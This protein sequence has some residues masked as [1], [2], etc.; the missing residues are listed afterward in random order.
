MI[1]A[2]I[3]ASG[4]NIDDFILSRASGYRTREKVASIV[5]EKDKIEF[6]NICE[7]KSKKL[8]LHFDGKLCDEL[9]PMKVDKD[10]RDRVAMLVRSP[11]LD[12]REQMLGIPEMLSGSGKK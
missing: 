5:T 2:V 6:R 12:Q 9:D 7:D 3:V 1:A 10:K 4:G 8:I 11:D